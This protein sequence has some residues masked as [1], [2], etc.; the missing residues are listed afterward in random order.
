MQSAID[1]INIVLPKE[2]L[3]DEIKLLCQKQF[4]SALKVRNI[5][6][7][8]ILSMHINDFY[9]IVDEKH[10]SLDR[11]HASTNDGKIAGRS[12]AKYE[13]DSLFKSHQS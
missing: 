5:T 10:C 6:L 13:D 11:I 4:D 12:A 1:S 8:C 9:R 2:T 3:S 7:Q